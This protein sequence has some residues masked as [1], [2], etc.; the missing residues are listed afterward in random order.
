MLNNVR[1]AVLPVVHHLAALTGI[2][3]ERQQG[4]HGVDR[5]RCS[6]VIIVFENTF[7]KTGKIGK[8]ILLNANTCRG[9]PDTLKLFRK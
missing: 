9:L 7:D 8:P 4:I 2:R 1:A 5:L 6:V 3:Q